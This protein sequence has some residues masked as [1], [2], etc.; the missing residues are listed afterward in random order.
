MGIFLDNVNFNGHCISQCWVI[1]FFFFFIIFYYF[2]CDKFLV[3][4]IYIFMMYI[5]CRQRTWRWHGEVEGGPP[6]EGLLQRSFSLVRQSEHEGK[7]FPQSLCVFLSLR[8]SIIAALHKSLVEF[9]V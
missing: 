8:S 1:F 5:R 4:V 6:V 3:T 7:L 9:R 2:N